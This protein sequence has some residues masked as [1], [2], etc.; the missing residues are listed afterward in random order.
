MRKWLSIGLVIVVALSLVIGILGPS[1]ASAKEKGAADTVTAF[2][3]ALPNLK[4]TAVTAGYWVTD[5]QASVKAQLDAIPKDTKISLKL[6]GKLKTTGQDGSP[7]TVTGTYKLEVKYKKAKSSVQ[8]TITFTLDK[9]GDPKKYPWLISNSDLDL[10]SLSISA[11]ATPTATPT[12][13]SSG[14]V[15]IGA[16]ASWSGAMAVTGGLA[17]KVISLVEKQVKDRGGMLGGREMKV[18]RYDNAGSVAQG[19]AG[20]KKLVFDDK[21]SAI[22]MGGVSGAEFDAIATAAEEAKVLFV[23]FGTVDDLA[24][25]KFTVNGT[26][27]RD[28]Y[29]PQL[30]NFALKIV[31]PKTAAYLGAES[32]D[33]NARIAGLKGGLE[34]AGVK[35]VFEQHFPATTIDFSPYL[36]KIKYENPDLLFLD[37]GQNEAY[38]NVAT[39]IK[40]LGGLGNTKVLGTPAL[41]YAR[42]QAAAEGWYEF[43][44]WVP[45]VEYPEAVKFYNEYKAMHGSA[46]SSSQVYNYNCLLV[47]IAAIE[48]AGTDTDLVKIAEVTRSGNL[49]LDTPMGRAHYTPDGQSGLGVVIAQI[50]EGQLVLVNVPK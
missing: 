13:S 27:Q 30:I 25:Y 41:E 10:K 1:V 47:A 38:V 12:S 34:K 48:L 15:K 9:K 39:Q 23:A 19:A 49:E 37:T 46:P 50:K 28:A 43:A 14:P 45:G 44:L 33:S 16:I 35:T 42:K 29:V 31:Q 32:S 22:T 4:K 20:V 8:K 24:K 26:V 11:T 40:E 2:V 5:K 3:K 7:A 18:V 36:T 21:V 17:D 6:V